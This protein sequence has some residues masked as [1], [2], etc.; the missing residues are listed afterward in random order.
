MP[1][2]DFL[3]LS[4]IYIPDHLAHICNMIAEVILMLLWSIFQKLLVDHLILISKILQMD[5]FVLFP[6]MM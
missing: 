4:F 1:G 2:F 5:E 3:S 6:Y